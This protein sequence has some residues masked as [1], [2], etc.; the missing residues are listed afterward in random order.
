VPL[1]TIGLLRMQRHGDVD[2]RAL[3]WLLSSLLVREEFFMVIVGALVA[4]PFSLTVLKRQWKLRLIGCV[5]A[6]GWWALYWFGIRTW[7]GDGSDAIAQSVFSEFSEATSTPEA[8]TNARMLLAVAVLGAGG[9]LA[10][11]GWKWLAP[12]GPGILFLFTVERMPELLLN[13]HYGQFVAPGL[14][15]AIVAGFAELSRASARSQRIAIPTIAV[16]GC[17]VFVLCSALPGGQRFQRD[18]FLLLL[19]AEEAAAVEG[20]GALHTMVNSVP[21]DAS[22]AGPYEVGAL[23]AAREDFALTRMLTHEYSGDTPPEQDWIVLPARNW[24]NVGQDLVV[25][26]GYHLIEVVPG[27]AALL[28]RVPDQPLRGSADVPCHTPI[29]DWPEAAVTLCSI[30]R[31]A[32]GQHHAMMR[33]HGEADSEL[34]DAPLFF[35][36]AVNGGAVTVPLLSERGMLPA[37]DI[38]YGRGAVFSAVSPLPSEAALVLIGPNGQ[39]LTALIHGA[40]QPSVMVPI[41]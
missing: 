10:I 32:R 11:R 36:A 31:D 34:R 16:V 12:A 37:R 19:D 26:H 29:A 25:R 6:V 40:E 8:I 15:V 2:L 3:L 1:L 30:R 14:V 20:L 17:L 39:P 4:A 22:L 35:L 27:V 13:V 18:H 7:I 21:P 5:I 9:G 24:S 38:P 41:P 33:R 28:S 23:A